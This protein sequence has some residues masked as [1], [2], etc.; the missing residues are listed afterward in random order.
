[1]KVIIAGGREITNY[2][3]VCKAVLFANFD[4]TEIVSGDARGVDRLG[5]RLGKEFDIP[6][7]KFPADWD[8]YQKAA[9]FIRNEEMA[10][11]AD[12][13]IA[14]WDGHSRGTK[15][16]ITRANKKELKVYVHLI[17]ENEKYAN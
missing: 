10:C 17:S 12:G 15:D 8:K 4:I 5:E 16:M 2:E 3:T 1:M 9:G 7:K 6:V 14:I 13:L 11:Y